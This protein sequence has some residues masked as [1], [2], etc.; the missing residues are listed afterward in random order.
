[1]GLPIETHGMAV[2]NRAL[3]AQR[4]MNRRLAEVSRLA[5]TRELRQLCRPAHSRPTDVPSRIIPLHVSLGL[6]A[7]L[8]TQGRQRG[9]SHG[10]VLL[11]AALVRCYARFGI[12]GEPLGPLVDYRGPRQPLLISVDEIGERIQRRC[13]P[14]AQLV[15]DFLKQPAA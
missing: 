8:Y 12:Q 3:T 5:V 6:L 7:L 10:V 4:G 13:P 9:I 14:R 11:D 1:G 2:V 15:S